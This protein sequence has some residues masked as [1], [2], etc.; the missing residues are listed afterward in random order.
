MVV[1]NKKSILDAWI[2]VEQLSEGDIKK[3]DEQYRKF[4]ENDD[5]S[6]QLYDFMSLQKEREKLTDR[7]FGASGVAIYCGIFPFQE[8][9]EKLRKQYRLQPTDEELSTSEKFTFALYFNKDLIFQESKFFF[10]MSGYIR[11]RNHLPDDFSKIEDDVRDDVKKKFEDGMFNDVFKQLLSDYRITPDNCRYTFVKNLEDSVHLHSFFIKD[12]NAAK[13][14]ST[15]NLKRYLSGFM[16]KRIDLDC[17]PLSP[18]INISPFKD[19]LEP[20]NY[21]LGRFPSEVEHSLSMMQQVAVN[22]SLNGK[23]NIQS[24]NGPPGTGKT[25]LLKDI[26]AQLIVEQAKIICELKDP[27]LKA[28]LVYDSPYKIASLPFSIADKGIVVASSNNG[29]VQNIVNELPQKEKIEGDIFIEELDKVDYFTEIANQHFQT[30]YSQKNMDEKW[31]LFSI[32][33]GSSHNLYQLRSTLE[34]ILDELKRTDYWNN[35]NIYHEFKQQYNE[36]CEERQKTQLLADKTKEL[37]DLKS[38]KEQFED[39]FNKDILEKTTSLNN[40][41]EYLKENIKILTDRKLQIKLELDSIT[42]HKSVVERQLKLAQQEFEMVKLQAPRFLWFKKLFSPTEASIYLNELNQ[43]HSLLKNLTNE[44]ADTEQQYQINHTELKDYENRIGNLNQEQID[45]QKEYNTWIKGQ[46]KY[47]SDFQEKINRLQEELAQSK[48]DQPDFSK[49]YDQLQTSNFWFNKKYRQDQSMLFIKAMAVKKQFLF[50]NRKHFEKALWIWNNQRK[51]LSKDNG[52]E[53][54]QQAW[55]WI[56]FAIPVISTTFA[57]FGR[58]FENLSINSIGHL[59]IDEAGQALPQ[60]S[61]GAIF[62]SRNILVVGDPSQIQPVLSLDKNILGLIA[63]YHNVTDNYLSPQ[64]STQSLVDATSQFGFQKLDDTWIGIPLWVHRRSSDPMFSISNKI[65]YNDLMVQGKI[66]KQGGGKWFDIDGLA[67]DKFVSR[68]AEFL[69]QELQKRKA[70][71]EDIYVIT[72]FRNVAYQLAK[73]LNK[74]HFTKY[75]KR[76]SSKK[77]KPI[78]VGTVHTFQGK[79][80]KVVYF[81]LGADKQSKGAAAWAVSDPNIMNVAVTRAKEEF[82]IIGD[83]ELYQSLNSPVINETITILNDYTKKE[84][85][86][87]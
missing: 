51:Y 11:Y 19:I 39:R 12:L 86:Q 1:N 8:I 40:Q 67:K 4:G 65:S 87:N 9:V 54:I 36:L 78:N 47:L 75:E 42:N 41:L 45:K 53:L 5:F 71:F 43:A 76:G 82:Y 77:G 31:G 80:A 16:G 85:E 73:L 46:K 32:E 56:N 28:E 14:I 24:V 66:E 29:A 10:T 81:V 23:N 17:H 48:I 22:L 84:K 18:K 49:P 52:R 83:K 7:D 63:Q 6:Q 13:E 58:M 50:D 74:I 68:Q 55:N 79:E 37:S 15:G 2:M 61:V 25:T 44:F 34:K 69:K 20:Q 33:G 35:S 21:P 38:K 59:F 62:R 60:A 64:A 70:E 57:S 72:P 26:F 3:T 27:V 30:T